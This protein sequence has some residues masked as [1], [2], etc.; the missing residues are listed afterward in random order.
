MH[1]PASPPTNNFT[2]KLAGFDAIPS[3]WLC[4]PPDKDAWLDSCRAASDESVVTAVMTNPKPNYIGAIL[5]GDGMIVD[6][7]AN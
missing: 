1:Q 2:L 4:P 3:G 6:A 5:D 7:H